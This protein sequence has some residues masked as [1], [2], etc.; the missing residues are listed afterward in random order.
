M[1]LAAL[2][3]PFATAALTGL[4]WLTAAPAAA[5]TFPKLA[6]NPVV[7]QADIIPAGE[8]AA[9]NTQLLE[10]EQKT[11]HQLVV[12]T[13]SDL[14]GRD[15]ADY[16]YRLGREWQIGDAEKDDGVVFL[17]APNERRMHIA[18]GLGLE[19]VLTD[20][21]SGRIIRDTIT[22]RFKAN[23]YPG[24]I[25]AGVN[26]IAEQIQL[27]PE[28]AAARAQ[29][30][31]AQER[32]RADDGDIGGLI[33]VAFI[34]FFFFILPMLARIGR[35]GKKRRKGRPWD[36]PIIIWGSDDWGGG[37][38]GGSSWGGGSWGGG[39]G[40]GFGG[41]SGGG[42]SFGGGGASGGW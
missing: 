41:F 21:M 40:G 29:A 8:E 33:F 23:D 31:A 26:A 13:V 34:I 4:L 20:A 11:G 42:G 17:I 1:G 15:V 22:P 38:G 9:L 16:G 28:E 19:P 39:G 5:Q 6:G 25:Q 37:S 2:L 3:R 35:R 18:V 27:P 7:D 24:G 14:E 32:D 12:A 36:A 10:L 30:A